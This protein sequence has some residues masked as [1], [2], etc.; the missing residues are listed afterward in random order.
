MI[1]RRLL[2]HY[3]YQAIEAVDHD[4][5]LTIA[6]ERDV[7]LIVSELFVTRGDD[8]SCLV[9]SVRNDS[10]LADIP[11]LIV[12]TRAFGADEQRARQ[13]GSAGYI[14]KPFAATHVMAEVARLLDPPPS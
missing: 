8:A 2:E 4:V 7:A 12:T 13:A 14:V 1:L 9:E 6:R 10:V 11:V 5:A 3:G